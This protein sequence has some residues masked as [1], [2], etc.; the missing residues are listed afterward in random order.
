MSV[1]TT[2]SG[3]NKFDVLASIQEALH[4]TEVNS[5]EEVQE[6]GGTT[7]DSG[8]AKSVWPIQ[9]KGVVRT[10]SKK[11][12]EL[13]AAKGSAIRVEGDAK[14]EFIRESKKCCRRQEIVGISQRDERWR[15]QGR[16]WSGRIVH[17]NESTGQRI[18]MCRRKGV[19]VVQMNAV[20]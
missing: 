17:G 6:I 9:K 2:D 3:S 11:Q 1:T 15:K 8:A 12:V 4:D 7:V 16:V 14:L 13:A 10:T 18:P 5:G 19:F 20:T